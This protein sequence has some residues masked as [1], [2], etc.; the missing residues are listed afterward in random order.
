MPTRPPRPCTKPGCPNRATPGSGR[1][2]THRTASRRQSDAKRGNANDRGYGSEHRF[3][4][5]WHVL[6]HDPVC[7]LCGKQQATV[8]DHYPQSRRQLEAAGLDPNDPQYGRGLC[9]HCHNA[10]TARAQPGGF[11]RDIQERRHGKR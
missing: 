3:R 2:E 7:V 6:Q 11:N 5:R 4:F 10:Y 9:A 1:C 8:A